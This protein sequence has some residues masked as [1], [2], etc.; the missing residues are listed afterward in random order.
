MEKILVIN[1]S[2]F[3]R[4]VFK[5]VLNQLNKEVVESKEFEIYNKIEKVEPDVV[6]VN[7]IMKEIR[8]DNLIQEIK[9]R[10]PKLKCIL[11]SCNQI[12]LKDYRDKDVDAILQ[13]P[14]EQNK[15]VKVFEFLK[16]QQKKI[17]EPKTSKEK[18]EI[19]VKSDFSFYPCCGKK[20]VGEGFEK[21]S[22]CPYCG[23]EI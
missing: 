21:I 15:L 23:K 7:L 10:Y 17:T 19:E 16:N 14:V 22:F 12:N 18:N 9:K 1:D 6:I 11:S 5:Y 8:G 2:E 20:I 4:K 3:E 13:T